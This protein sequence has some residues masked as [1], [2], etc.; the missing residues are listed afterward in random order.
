MSSRSKNMDDK[1]V[2]SLEAR[3]EDYEKQ[4][5]DKIP[6]SI[7]EA[8]FIKVAKQ[9]LENELDMD[10]H[11]I[12]EYIEFPETKS[13]FQKIVKKIRT[14]RKKIV[15][16]ISDYAFPI[17]ACGVIGIIIGICC[18]AQHFDNEKA[19]AIEHINQTSI[20][21]DGLFSFDL[22]KDG[23][24]TDDERRT[25]IM[26][27][28]TDNNL[29]ANEEDFYICVRNKNYSNVFHKGEKLLGVDDVYEI[30][31]Q[32]KEKHETTSHPVLAY[33]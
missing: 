16:K 27:F 1:Y 29:T 2:A 20:K 12:S 14:I 8:A 5:A 11:T 6:V 31:S 15:R 24:V 19:R 23:V 10:Y 7:N 3:I 9:Y 28:A 32:Q 13:V 18:I 26:K 25:V 33:F 22:N 30:A 17:V 4:L 21:I